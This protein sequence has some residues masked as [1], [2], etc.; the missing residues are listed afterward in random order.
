LN[1]EFPTATECCLCGSAL[2]YN[3]EYF[4]DKNFL[5]GSMVGISL[6]EIQNNFI[7]AHTAKIVDAFCPNDRIKFQV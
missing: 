1:V 6:Y 7:N 5:I 2:V 3:V 4:D